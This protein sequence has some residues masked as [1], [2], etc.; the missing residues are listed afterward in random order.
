MDHIRIQVKE[1]LNISIDPLHIYIN[2]LSL[3][4]FPILARP[5]IEQ[6]FS[7]SVE[8]TEKFYAERKTML[9]EFIL[10]ALKGYENK[11]ND[12]V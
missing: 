7:L 8:Q 11:I 12:H 10:N 9:P 2:I 4:I 3:C 5:L 1:E 6:I